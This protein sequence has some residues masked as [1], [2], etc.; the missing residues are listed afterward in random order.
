MKITVKQF[1]LSL[2]ETVDGK[3]SGQVKAVIKKFVELI[4][5]KDMLAKA[6]KIAAQFVK[7]W[8]EKHGIVEAQV[9]SANGLDKASVKLLEN[10]ITKLSGAKEV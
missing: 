6:D 9:A 4:A 7:I 5:Q 10:Y 3:T 2:Y 1:A 8:N